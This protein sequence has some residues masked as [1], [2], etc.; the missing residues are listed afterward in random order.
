MEPREILKKQQEWADYVRLRL[1]PEKQCPKCKK[2][3]PNDREH[4]ATNLSG[5]LLSTCLTC[6][7]QKLKAGLKLKEICPCCENKTN[8]VTDRNAPAPVQLC[9]AC[10]ALINSLDSL[11]KE[12][13]N[14]MAQYIEW[15]KKGQ[16]AA[17]HITSA[18]A[19]APPR[20]DPDA[21]PAPPAPTQ[22]NGAAP[23]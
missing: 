23:T 1:R 20:P 3:F 21:R 14:R 6:A 18:G 4:F 13:A 16:L 12:T 11:D 15:R 2:T 10:L 5:R 22:G 17:I 19:P 8:L 7:P 9:R